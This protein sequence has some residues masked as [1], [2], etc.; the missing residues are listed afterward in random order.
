MLRTEDLPVGWNAIPEGKVSLD[1]GDAWLK[2]GTTA[3]L[4]VPSVI[5]P[6]ESNALINALHPDAKKI[7]ATKIR[8]WLYNNRMRSV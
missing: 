5:V 2:Q 8:P 6:E 1:A 4:Q 3:I 7:K